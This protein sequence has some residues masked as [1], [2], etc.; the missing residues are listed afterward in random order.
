MASPKRKISP[1]GVVDP[2]QRYTVP[3]SS[4]TLRQSVAKTYLDIKNGRLRVIKDGT[5]T[6]VPGVELIRRSTLPAEQSAA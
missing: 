5:R 1:P 4:A 6:Y 2:N 3:E